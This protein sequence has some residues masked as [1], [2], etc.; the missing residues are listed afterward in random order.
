MMPV[1]L[2]AVACSM[3]RA[4][5]AMSP[6][7]GLRYS[8]L[9]PRSCSAFFSAFL[10]VFHHESESGAWLTKT[11]RSPAACAGLRDAAKGKA[12]AAASTV[13]RIRLIINVLPRRRRPLRQ[14]DSVRLGWEAPAHPHSGMKSLIL[15]LIG[16]FIP[17]RLLVKRNSRAPFRSGRKRSHRAML[18]LEGGWPAPLRRQGGR[19][20]GL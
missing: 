8:T 7:D 17:Q 9:T 6:V 10:I 3:M 13:L 19:F 4:M 2:E 20:S 14:R 12:K 18:P 15:S 16:I 11:N 1:G 5:S